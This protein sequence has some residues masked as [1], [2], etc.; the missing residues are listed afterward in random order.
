MAT[1]DTKIGPRMMVTYEYQ[2]KECG[3]CGNPATHKMTFLLENARRNPASSAYG[4]DDCSYCSDSFKYCC[5]EHKEQVRNHEA[6]NGMEWCSDFYVGKN[7]DGTER[8]LDSVCEWGK[9]L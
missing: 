1:I 3:L 6:P 5:E 9:V 4:R 8:N 2:R 7:E